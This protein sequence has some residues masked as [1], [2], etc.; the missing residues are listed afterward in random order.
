M[1]HKAHAQL[2]TST[3]RRSQTSSATLLNDLIRFLER[4]AQHL[5]Q[6]PW[7][8][9]TDVDQFFAGLHMQV[10]VAPTRYAPASSQ[11]ADAR[12][13]DL[14]TAEAER[15]AYRSRSDIGAF[16]HADDQAPMPWSAQ[17]SGKS[18]RRKY[19][20]AIILADPGLGKTTLLRFEGW[21][22]AKEQ[23]EALRSGTQTIQETVIPI[24]IRL[25][26][27]VA[28]RATG[29][30]AKQLLCFATGAGTARAASQSTGLRSLLL[31]QIRSGRFVALLDA[32]DEVGA[33]GYE[34]LIERVSKI[35]DLQPTRAYLTSRHAGYR[36]NLLEQP[37]RSVPELEIVAFSR[38]DVRRFCHAY[39][40]GE[41]TSDG[42]VLAESVWE[43]LRGNSSLLGLAQT[44]LLLTMMCV[45][46]WERQTAGLSDMRLPTRR[47]E[48]YAECV[49]GLLGGWSMYRDRKLAQPRSKSATVEA[50]IAPRRRLVARLAWELAAPNL[51]K[52]LYSWDDLVAA[53]DRNQSMVVAMGFRNAKAALDLLW[54]KTGVLTAEGSYYM[55]LH[56]TFQEYLVA[57]DIARLVNE[58][59]W[60]AA[61][62]TV[63]LRAQVLAFPVKELLERMSW[64]PRWQEII[65]LVTGQLVDPLPMLKLLSDARRDDIYR[66][67]LALAARCLLEIS[68][69]KDSADSAVASASKPAGR[70][71][72]RSAG[73]SIV[74]ELLEKCWEAHICTVTRKGIQDT[75]LV[76]HLTGS[77]SEVMRS[78]VAVPTQL[79]AVQN[80][81][82]MASSGDWTE[83]NAALSLLKSLPV[84]DVAIANQSLLRLLSD[85]D[86]AA[87]TVAASVIGSRA[88]DD[89][90][91]YVDALIDC[92]Q[93]E[94]R[95]VRF[96]TASALAQLRELIDAHQLNRIA[97][98]L[99]HQHGGIRCAAARAV[100]YLGSYCDDLQYEK[101]RALLW[102]AS[103]GV[104]ATAAEALSGMGH[105]LTAAD[106]KHFVQLLQ[107]SAVVVRNAAASAIG[108]VQWRLDDTE[109]AEVIRLTRHISDDARYAAAR[110]L[111]FMSDRHDPQCIDALLRLLTDVDGGV[112]EAASRSLAASSWIF[113]PRHTD[114]LRQ[115]LASDTSAYRAAAAKV[116]GYVAERVRSA[117][118][119]QLIAC[120]LDADDEVRS[121]SAQALC[122]TRH[123]FTA[124]HVARLQSLLK[125]ADEGVRCAVAEALGP[126]QLSATADELLRLCEQN[127]AGKVG[128]RYLAIE[129]IGELGQ[130]ADAR[131]LEVLFRLCET[132]DDWT[133]RTKAVMALRRW[134]SLGVRVFRLE[135]GWE[136]RSVLDL[137]SIADSNCLIRLPNV[138]PVTS[139]S[140]KAVRAETIGRVTHKSKIRSEPRTKRQH[141][142]KIST[143]QIA[144]LK[145]KKILLDK[146]AIECEQA[147]RIF[148]KFASVLQNRRANCN[149]ISDVCKAL[150]DPDGAW[151]SEDGLPTSASSFSQCQKRVQELFKRQFGT[152]MADLLL[153][154]K[155]S[156]KGA[157]SSFGIVVLKLIDKH[158][159]SIEAGQHRKK[160]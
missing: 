34:A 37:N 90:T 78:F 21:K 6:F 105:L 31:R 128:L 108:E 95:G 106:I 8:R 148:H 143:E 57:S 130:A 155:T 157:L 84:P 118:I 54:R 160:T 154:S 63:R 119:D 88:G 29:D 139:R 133:T 53:L 158:L 12:G 131:H 62:V 104:Q 109:F 136:T 44:P 68:S 122:A 55:F 26:D 103:P 15:R 5:Q 144:A 11:P 27:I 110:A 36:G 140:D 111:G 75:S 45:A 20:W 66:H 107:S 87:K 80:V 93:S 152:P 124:A 3:M 52:T 116:F 129:A 67:R 71:Q 18:A 127:D 113:Q 96:G 125:D 121:A 22:A 100:R 73:E 142:E 81:L 58:H 117:D 39:F 7:P 151:K 14:E 145:R 65:P 99:D 28:E 132:R 72:A 70:S 101:A 1:P 48:L 123:R 94:H 50:T 35:L 120:I 51:D 86:P 25:A 150:R 147:M 91:R 24:F 16:S 60:E 102:N 77:L 74:Q 83:R 64:L 42:H 61:T 69:P 38:D 19:D 23:I 40:A 85:N 32:Q 138:S 149:S 9:P 79:A 126:L 137:G 115:L 97:G 134:Q 156:S 92:L 153:T 141:A 146:S 98:Y 2:K 10:K 41:R 47:S 114:L 33:R 82:A 112:R 89:D 43:A 17:A 159:K 30:I 76:F 56:L 4:V 59:G 46:L 49:F 13:I 135:G